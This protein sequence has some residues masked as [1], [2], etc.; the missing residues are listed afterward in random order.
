MIR[1]AHRN[2]LFPWKHR[3][4]HCLAARGDEAKVASAMQ[5]I[6]EEDQTLSY[7]QDPTTKE[8]ILSGLG[9]QH[10]AAVVSRLQSD[11]GVSVTLTSI[12][13]T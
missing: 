4:T 6:L 9:E 7:E 1:F 11:F 10:L 13:Q 8:A 5:K 2:K 12:L 3:N